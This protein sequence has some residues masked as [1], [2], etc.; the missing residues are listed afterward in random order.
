LK[1]IGQYALVIFKPIIAFGW[2][3]LLLHI[4]GVLGLIFGLE[5]A[6][7]VFRGLSQSLRAFSMIFVRA[8]TASFRLLTEQFGVDL[9]LGGNRFEFLTVY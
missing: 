3:A 9:N 2:S 8:T 6:Y 5:S 4:L 1:R 7:S